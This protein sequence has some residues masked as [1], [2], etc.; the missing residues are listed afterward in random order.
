MLRDELLRDKF[1]AFSHLPCLSWLKCFAILMLEDVLSYSV[2]LERFIIIA[3]YGPTVG[4]MDISHRR[5]LTE[6]GLGIKDKRLDILMSRLNGW[7]Y[8]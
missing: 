8:K 4:D 7:T 5:G 6:D 2:H 1:S 3:T